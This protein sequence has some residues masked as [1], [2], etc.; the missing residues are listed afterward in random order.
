MITFESRQVRRV[1]GRLERGESL[2]E[3]LVDL[4]AKR[5]IV[6]GSLSGLGAVEWVELCEYDQQSR[7]Y[8]SP[9][10]VEHAEI[11][12]LSGNLSIRDG[13]VFAHVHGTF[14]R[15]I[16]NESDRRIEVVGGHVAAAQV[17]ACEFVVD[18]YDDIALQ[19]KYDARTGLDLWFDP[20]CEAEAEAET[21]AGQ[22]DAA[23][24]GAASSSDS[25]L[26]WS[27]VAAASGAVD[28]AASAVGLPATGGSAPPSKRVQMPKPG[29]DVEHK[30]FGRCRIVGRGTDGALILKPN[31]GGRHRKVKLDQFEI[32]GPSKDNGRRV[33]V[34][35][36]KS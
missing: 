21:Q 27:Q 26:S 8:R 4:A 19:R 34:L 9:I 13:V 24:A 14:S 1:V 25:A 3:G 6:S 10:R 12:S 17:F 29:D 35:R 18:C 11:L 23:R 2:L 7:A 28:K 30:T 16:G 36:A 32:L 20:L 5:G 22:G 15:E 31:S 33:F